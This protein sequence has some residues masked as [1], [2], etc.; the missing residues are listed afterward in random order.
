MDSEVRPWGEYI[1]LDRG[2][3]HVTKRIVLAPGHRFSDQLHKY[4]WEHWVLVAG[5]LR[6]EKGGESIVMDPGE[7]LEIPKWTW[8]RA[9]NIGKTPAIIIET[10]YGDRLAE[11]D[12]LRRADDYGRLPAP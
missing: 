9:R 4:R 12:I 5:K 1:V 8:H 11:E 10:W 7:C 3:R 6:V 2:E